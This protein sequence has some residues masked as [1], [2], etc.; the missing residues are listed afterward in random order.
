MVV[1]GA[2]LPINLP[3]LVKGSKTKIAPIVS[4]LKAA[5]LI[6]RQW[7]KKYDRLPDLVVIEGPLAGGHLGFKRE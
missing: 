4:S 2:G 1:S 3:E 7:K 5:S 6:V